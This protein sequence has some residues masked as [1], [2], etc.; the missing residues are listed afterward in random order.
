VATTGGITALLAAITGAI[1]GVASYA[2]YAPALISV[3]TSATLIIIS[4]VSALAAVPIGFLGYWSA[5]RR[6]QQS[7]FALGGIFL[8]VGTLGSWLVVVTVALGR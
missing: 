1:A 3:D 4:V 7:G 6:A 8:A 2:L 5:E